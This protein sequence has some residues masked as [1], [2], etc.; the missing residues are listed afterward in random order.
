MKK[1]KIIIISQQKREERLL[2]MTSLICVFIFSSEFFSF[3][4]KNKLGRK[5]WKIIYVEWIEN[6]E[7]VRHRD[8]T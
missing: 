2:S 7:R 8:S 5:R 6:Q 1:K 4:K 3:G